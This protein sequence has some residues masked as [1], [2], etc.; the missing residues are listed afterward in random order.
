MSLA[1]IITPKSNALI[2]NSLIY[3]PTLID[4]DIRI[5]ASILSTLERGR[6]GYTER[7]EAGQDKADSKKRQLR[8]KVKR[9]HWGDLV[10][11]CLPV[12]GWGRDY[13]QHD[14]DSGK[15]FLFK[16][17]KTHSRTEWKQKGAWKFPRFQQIQWFKWLSLSLMGRR[18]LNPFQLQNQII[19][20]DSVLNTL[21]LKQS[22]AEPERNDEKTTI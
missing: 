19:I 9:F 12:I 21:F 11:P 7:K 6:T 17:P 2:A 10:T 22:R 3:Y 14:R 1:V 15:K 5:H 8:C 20:S 18:R 4:S 16:Y 13:Q